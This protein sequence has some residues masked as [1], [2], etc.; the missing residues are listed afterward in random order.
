MTY[1][2]E[3]PLHH[4]FIANGI[5]SH[6]S[7]AVGYAHLTYA[8]AFL[9]ANYPLEFFKN[10]INF[11]GDDDKPKYLSAA[12]TR[13]I[14]IFSPDINT[15]EMLISIENEGLRLGLQSMKGIGV[16]FA[17]K[18][19]ERRPFTCMKEVQERLGKSIVA[20]LHGANALGSVPD[21][22][23]FS[24]LMKVDEA[25]VLGISL[26]GLI[27][28]YQDVVTNVSAIPFVDVDYGGVVVMKMIEVKMIQD[29]RGRD[30]SFI[31]AV[32]VHGPKAEGLVMFAS[33]YEDADNVHP[34]KGKVYVMV[35]ARLNNGGY[36]V[37]YIN[38]VDS[39]REKFFQQETSIDQAKVDE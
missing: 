39:V 35:L 20:T 29:R 36:Q 22:G 19:V 5:I 31:D 18:I 15:S 24:P 6:N 2:L 9:S 8:C 4:N 27:E 38:D 7:H 23:S 3:M 33:A 26:K 32:D 12:M 25:Q 1:D 28:E 17:K 16:A 14:K 37:K 13:K 11:E 34:E 21:S 10:L 30:M